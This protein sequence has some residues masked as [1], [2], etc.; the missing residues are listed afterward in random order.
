VH[1]LQGKAELVKPAEQ[2]TLL[3]GLYRDK[4]ALHDRHERGARLVSGYE[5]N[6]T[7]QYVLNREAEHLSWLAAAIEGLG[8]TVPADIPVIPMPAAAGKDAGRAVIDDD[9]RHVLAFVEKWQ[10]AVGAMGH[11][12]HRKMVDLLLGETREQLR[13]F[14]QAAAGRDDLLGRR[15]G[16]GTG[17]GVLPT[18]WVE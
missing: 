10:P 18:R 3:A 9:A 14:D 16:V 13:F 2:Q 7:Y 4:R 17:G 12:R 8:G 11:A 1:H 6:N 5:F 15:A